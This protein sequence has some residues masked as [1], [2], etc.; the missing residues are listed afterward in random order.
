MNDQD[1]K[2]V[3]RYIAK[4]IRYA[5]D[6]ND[7]TQDDLAAALNDYTG[8][9]WTREIIANLESGRKAIQ[10]ED[11]CAIAYV[12]GNAVTWYFADAPDTLRDLIPGLLNGLSFGVAPNLAAYST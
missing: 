9:G 2:Q 12:Q 11:L 8:G 6:L 3:R 10:V 7:H 4:R 5:R 1:R